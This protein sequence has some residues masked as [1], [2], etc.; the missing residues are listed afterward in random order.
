MLE[1]FEN[2]LKFFDENSIKKL[3]VLL[4]LENLLLKIV[5]GNNIIFLQQ[6]F[7]VS[8]GFHP[9]PP[10]YAHA[11]RKGIPCHKTN[12]KKFQAF[13]D[14][15]DVNF[16]VSLKM[17]KFSIYILKYMIGSIFK[18]RIFGRQNKFPHTLKVTFT[19]ANF[20]IIA[21]CLRKL[22]ANCRKFRGNCDANI[23]GMVGPV[24]W[25]KWCGSK[26]KMYY[27]PGPPRSRP[28]S[29]SPEPKSLL[30]PYLGVSY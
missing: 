10:G 17:L 3:N 22:S 29:V 30:R 5:I 27:V 12:F 26:R 23:V 28:Q 9:F 21:S 2:I 19:I 11:I 25:V 4:F 6:F 1:N 8:G 13:Q 24:G 15:L 18:F 16:H 20:P 14:I 7:S